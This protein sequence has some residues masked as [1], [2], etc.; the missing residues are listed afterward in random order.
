MKSWSIAHRLFALFLFIV[1]LFAVGLG[2]FYRADE[3]ESDVLDQ[4][5]RL[6][7]GGATIRYEMMVMSDALRGLLLDP[8]HT[9]ERDRKRSADEKFTKALDRLRPLLQDH[10]ELQ[11]AAQAIANFDESK[12]NRLETQLVEMLARD[13]SGAVAFYNT[14]YL[15]AREEQEKL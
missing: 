9:S 13:G 11:R 14:S 7:D 12:L 15:P 1:V 6:L 8:T 2:V 4:R 3:R 5:E 10:P